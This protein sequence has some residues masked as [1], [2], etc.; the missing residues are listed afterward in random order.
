[1]NYDIPLLMAKRQLSALLP[2]A[3]GAAKWLPG[4]E[5]S[6]IDKHGMQ[7]VIDSLEEQK[8][9]DMTTITNRL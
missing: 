2:S 8:E 3:A 7:Q 9:V 6:A 4:G 5:G 1:M